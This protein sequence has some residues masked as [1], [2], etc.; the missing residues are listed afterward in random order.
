M[1]LSETLVRSFVGTRSQANTFSLSGSVMKVYTQIRNI[2]DNFTNTESIGR[3]I[4]GGRGAYDGSLDEA[5]VFLIAIRET[6]ALAEQVQSGATY[7]R[8]LSDAAFLT[9]SLKTA[10]SPQIFLKETIQLAE[11]ITRAVSIGVLLPD[12]LQVTD[13]ITKRSAMFVDLFDSMGFSASLARGISIS[14]SMDE[15]LSFRVT[16]ATRI[17]T[18]DFFEKYGL[19]MMVLLGLAAL[20][21]GLAYVRRHQRHRSAKRQRFEYPL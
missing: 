17:Y 14:I 10:F 19:P 2:A 16:T 3:L 15:N 20:I 12:I 6:F 21:V 5:R 8:D 9:S 1:T 13:E 11:G 7:L 4:D 18:V